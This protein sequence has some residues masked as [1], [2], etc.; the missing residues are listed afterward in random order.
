LRW[1]NAAFD[2]AMHWEEHNR[3]EATAMATGLDV[4]DTT[5]QHTNLWLKDLMRRLGTEDRKLAYQVL[6]RTLHAVRDR[7]GPENAAHLGAQLPMLV[8]GFYYEGWHMAGTPTKERLTEDFLE[9]VNT[10]VLR[11]LRLDPEKAVRAVFETM[12]EKLDPGEIEK[13]VKVFPSELRNLWPAVRAP[14]QHDRGSAP[15]Q[16]L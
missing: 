15:G 5:L 11:G 4:F 10:H 14:V 12:C 8:R 13:V 7:I 1:I 3:E 9:H 16:Y 2:P 6:S